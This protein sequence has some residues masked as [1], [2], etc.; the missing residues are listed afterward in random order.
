MA[1]GNGANG[2]FSIIASVVN[3]KHPK[4]GLAIG[5]LLGG[6][7]FVTSVV[8]G[9]VILMKPFKIAKF[10][11]LWDIFVYL[12]G[13]AWMAFMMLF[14]RKLYFW[15]PA[16]EVIKENFDTASINKPNPLKRS[17]SL[18]EYKISNA[19]IRLHRKTIS[20]INSKIISK[21]LSLENEGC[22][23]DFPTENF[24]MH[25]L[26]AETIVKETGKHTFLFI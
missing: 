1:F 7:A 2:I 6:G 25:D 4:A 9:T 26:S 15:E 17:Q 19:L 13:I 18:Y 16:D 8:F 23:G 14:D 21:R 5:D 20:H 10:A 22:I 11:T 12:I 24:N 3:T